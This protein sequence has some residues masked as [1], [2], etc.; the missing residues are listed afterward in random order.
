MNGLEH[1]RFGGG[2][3]ST[4][5]H[6]AV[7]VA[8]L[9]AVVVLVCLPKKWHLPVFLFSTFL[10]PAG[11]QIV[12]G[13][14]HVFVY[15]II[16]LAGCTRL[17]L[18]ARA[19]KSSILAGGRNSIDTAFLLCILFHVVAF[20]ILYADSA[21]IVNQIGYIWDYVGGYI[22]LR[23]LIRTEDDV[24]TAVKSFAVLSIILAICMVREQV[25]GRNIFGLLG[26]VRLSSEVRQGR[27]RSQGVFQHAILAG[28][29]GA[30]L[31]PSLLLLWNSRSNRILCIAGV[32]AAAV[33]TIATAC[34]TPVVTCAAGALALC[35]WPL[36]RQMRLLRWGLLVSLFAL[37]I[38]MKGPVWALIGHIDLVQGSS[39]HHRYELVNQFVTHVGDWFLI[40][41]ASNG[42][43][44][45]EMVDTS[46]AYVEEGTSGGLLAFVCFLAIIK[47]SFSRI[48]DARK[49]L[50]RNRR[51][52]WSVWLLGA[53]LF[54]HVIAFFGIYYFDQ[55]RFAWFALLAMISVSSNVKIALPTDT[56]SA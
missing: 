10:I 40:G 20:T 6:P 19:G 26:G 15:R 11:Q 50:Q 56:K 13:G 16:V 39:S 46:N 36:R 54:A 33:M 30:T 34:S 45:D 38:A 53:A 4:I 7:L 2:Q 21:A 1:G 28:T 25:T 22:V 14:V 32:L 8:L 51:R 12:I 37:H 3:T 49:A 27:I 44:G 42:E 48:G 41:T 43:W 47:S 31:V 52:E 17:L 35:F 24:T 5:L 29:F 55:M 23:N 18:S 9:L